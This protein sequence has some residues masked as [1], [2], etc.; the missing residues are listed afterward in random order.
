MGQ[1]DQLAGGAAR[2]A[3][4]RASGPRAGRGDLDASRSIPIRRPCA[5]RACPPPFEPVGLRIDRAKGSR[6]WPRPEAVASNAWVSGSRA[7]GGRQADPRQRPPPRRPHLAGLLLSR[8]PGDIRTAARRVWRC[9]GGA[10]ESSW[11]A[12][13]ASPFGATNGY[14]DV[15]DLYIEREDPA[16][17]GHYLEGAR[18]LPLRGAQRASF[19]FAIATI[20]D[21][22]REESPRPCAARGGGRSSRITPC[23]REEPA[24]CSPCAGAGP[25]PC[26]RRWEPTRSMHGALGRGGCSTSPRGSGPFPLNYIL[27]DVDGHIAQRA[28]GHHPHPARGRRLPSTC[29][30]V[31]PR[32]SWAGFLSSRAEAHGLRSRPKAG[33]APRIT[34]WCP[35]A[36]PIAYSTYF[37]PSWRYR[38]LRELMAGESGA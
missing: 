15:V 18:S 22:F 35:T 37:A 19:A 20:P 33:S 26:S 27:A 7:L 13:S 16:N 2:P 11:D 31:T 34:T 5:K 14:A 23:H 28:L 8:G 38:R 32:D 9:A 17:P 30:C 25:R 36:T 10:R 24:R 21:G 6:H 29:P 12:R 4:D 3:A 1:L